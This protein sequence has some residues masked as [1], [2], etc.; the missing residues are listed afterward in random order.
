[1]LLAMFQKIVPYDPEPDKWG[2]IY[3]K[4]FEERH[5]KYNQDE[6]IRNAIKELI[7]SGACLNK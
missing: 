2:S 7:K 3:Y 6:I 5:G 1:M 4:V